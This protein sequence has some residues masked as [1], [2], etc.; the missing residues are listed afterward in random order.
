MKFLLA[1]HFLVT[2]S[3]VGVI[4]LQKSGDTAL[5]IGGNSSGGLLTARGQ[6][7]LLTKITGWLATIFILNCILMA[8]ISKPEHKRVSVI[9][10]ASQEQ[11]VDA[12]VKADTPPPAADSKPKVPTAPKK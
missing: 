6:A 7:N 1:L 12:P 8:S 10:Q 11:I 2:L 9:D 3:L 4:L 5:G